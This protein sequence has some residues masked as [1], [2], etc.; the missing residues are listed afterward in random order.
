MQIKLHLMSIKKKWYYFD[1]QRKKN[2][3]NLKINGKS[4]YYSSYARYLGI[5]LDEHLS[6]SYHEH[7]FRKK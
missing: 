7:F 1:T 3:Y 2:E 6:W 4:I 5:I